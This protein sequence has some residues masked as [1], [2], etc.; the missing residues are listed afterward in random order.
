MLSQKII[1]NHWGQNR[2]FIQAISRLELATS[3][4]VQFTKQR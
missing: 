3:N 2:F 4:I 1:T